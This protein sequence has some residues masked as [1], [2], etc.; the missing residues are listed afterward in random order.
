MLEGCNPNQ[1]CPLWPTCKEDDHHIYYPERVVRRRH[2]AAFFLAHVVRDV[3]R[4]AHDR[5]HIEQ[6][7]NYPDEQDLARFAQKQEE[8]K[9]LRANGL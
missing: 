4:A 6:P 7:T 2:G 3:C 5:L 8:L 1:D 9:R